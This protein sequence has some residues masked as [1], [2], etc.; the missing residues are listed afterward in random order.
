M[1]TTQEE[2]VTTQAWQDIVT[3]LLQK[4]ASAVVQ[5]PRRS[6]DEAI[7]TWL[8]RVVEV[9]TAGTVYR[10]PNIPIPP[11]Y[12]TTVRQ[13][14]HAGAPVGYVA[15]N[16]G[17]V[18]QSVTRVNLQDGESF[19]IN[20]TNMNQVYFGADTNSTFFEIISEL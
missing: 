12:T 14:R 9:A 10:G 19:E 6:D 15:P 8:V 13:R 7:G 3:S 4:I 1:T 11:G 20:I 5:R 18:Q 17:D 2:K 16:R